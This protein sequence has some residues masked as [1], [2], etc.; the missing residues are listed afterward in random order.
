MANKISI[1]TL[2]FE[3]KD[4]PYKFEKLR[5][6]GVDYIHCDIMDGVFVPNKT[7]TPKML[8]EIA[9][10]INLPLDVHLMVENPLDY[11]EILSKCATYYTF[12]CECF[13]DKKELDNA[14]NQVKN[15]GLKVGIAVDLNTEVTC[16]EAILNK[17]D[18]VL[19][20]SVKAGAGGQ[21]FDENSLEKI[22]YFDNYR[23]QYNL[24]YQIEVDGGINADN[25]AKCIQ[26]GA[27][28]V[29]SGSYV[30]KAKDM[31]VAINSLR[32]N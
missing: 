10:K 26:M 29:V 31:Q 11:L 8:S 6:L 28:I 5:E 1:S 18:L 23:K 3:F 22:K 17:I 12:H 30:A 24:N 13:N 27:N 14:I 20:M 2:P 21:K 19:V 7:Y 25:V 16:I 9:G 15:K 4:I 32:I